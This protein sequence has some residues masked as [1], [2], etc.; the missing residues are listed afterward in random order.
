MKRRLPLVAGALLVAVAVAFCTRTFLRERDRVGDAL[1][2]ARPAY[3]LLAVL[4]AAAAMATVVAGWRR[5]L[6]A[7]GERADGRHVARWYLV[8]ELGKYVPGGIWPVVGRAELARRD[9]V[10]RSTAYQSVALSLAAWYGSAV[11]PVAVVAAHPAVQG[12]VARVAAKASG[13]RFELQVLPWRT[14]VRLVLGYLPSWLLVGATTAAVVTAYGGSVGWRAPVVAVV[15]WVCGF[16]AVP[17]PAGAGVRE[18]VFV[19]ASGLPD[20][21][22]LT[23]AITARLAF[24]VVDLVGA[25]VAG[26]A[27]RP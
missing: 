27:A 18:A 15:A 6:A 17:V 23:V 21:L 9:G 14:L 4:L 3:L 7:L 2:D 25:A 1:G 20:G 8:G 12:T 5:C 22:A 11:A 19:A 26:A 24:I 16:A 10:P 13:G